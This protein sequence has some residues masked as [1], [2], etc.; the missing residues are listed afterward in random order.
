MKKF[1]LKLQTK[2]TLLVIVIVML[3][4][5]TVTILT[6]I[7]SI[8]NIKKE[9][10][11]NVLN[12]GQI[13]S[14]TPIVI[15]SL[16]NREI[17]IGLQPYVM[18]L[19]ESTKDIDIIV[20]ADMEGIRLAHPVEARIGYRVV[21]GDD[22]DVIEFGKSYAS[23]A[24]GTL[25]HQVRSFTPVHDETG[26]Q[27]GYVIA[28]VLTTTIETT[29]NQIVRTL[30]LSAL[31][32]LI[33][34]SAGA[35]FL[36]RNIKK[37][38]FG[39]EPDEIAKIYL[40]KESILE[41]I[42][43]GIIAIDENKK[44]TLINSSA[45]AML[46]IKQNQNIGRGIEE[47]VPNS[48]LPYVLESGEPE[49]DR[50]QILNGAVIISNRIAI[51]N[52]TQIVGALATFRDKTNIIKLAEELTG[53]KQL[54]EGLRANTHEFMNKLHVILGLIEL[55]EFEEAKKYIVNVDYLQN[56]IV[57]LIMNRIKEPKMA[58]LL[59]GKLSRAREL[60]V[61]MMI[62][63]STYLEK[64][65]DEINSNRILTVMGNMIENA[66]DAVNEKKEEPKEICV[67]IDDFNHK[68]VM[69]VTDTGV[70]IDEEN[71]ERIFQRGFSTKEGNR[72]IGLA[73]VKETLDN[74]GGSIKVSS[75][76]SE[77]TRFT[78][79]IP[80]EDKND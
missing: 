49:H 27:I 39:L 48:R 29:E 67:K 50:E 1:H 63:E 71:I 7:W 80:K 10:E 9:I 19:L 17:N 4:I 53:A 52:G 74:I 43:E 33:L 45:L 79:E 76:G 22:N 15:D 35:F 70:G 56:Q 65:N 2:I 12:I 20:V 16:K 51:R 34:G 14:K 8:N 62:D 64:M 69:T 18:R 38:I 73:L 46:G 68:L 47:V 55:D 61:K 57:H 77:G 28:G 25:G 42:H 3:S 6:S 31:V 60:G 37:I 11:K 21:G 78:V 41:T 24:T 26:K 66:L 59:I 44:I 40:E 54:V 30:Y 32:G 36:A 58:A 23:Y 5:S 75:N 13:L 72:G